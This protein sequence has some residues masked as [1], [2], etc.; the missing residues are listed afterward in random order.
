MFILAIDI[1]SRLSN[2]AQAVKLENNKIR[3]N[4]IA[5]KDGGVQLNTVDVEEVIRLEVC[6]YARTFIVI[7]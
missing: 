5:I 3:L 4:S 7:S 1:I 2:A 6:L